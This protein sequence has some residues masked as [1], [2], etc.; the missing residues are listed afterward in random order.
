MYREAARI[1]PTL[2]DA[3][4]TLSTLG[5]TSEIVLVDDGSGDATT[6]A[7]GAF[8]TDS[9]SGWLLRVRLVRHAVNRGKG[10]AV[11]TGLGESRGSWRLM[12]DA[13]NATRVR[14]V[15]KLLNGIGPG[16]GLVAGSRCVADS[17]VEARGFRVF[18]GSVFKLGLFALGLRLCRDTQCG[19]KLYRGDV[20]D[21]VV[22]HGVE[23]RFAF[24]IEHLLL[25]RRMGVAVREV[26]VRWRHVDGGTINPVIDGLRMLARAATI[27]VRRYKGL[28]DLR[29][30]GR[31]EREIELKPVSAVGV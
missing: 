12:M 7:V 28:P 27:R 22:R 18:A 5:I 21:A 19:F 29:G 1:A 17:D 9:R 13:D 24:D 2:T 6:D 8:V 26:G 11:R 16:V 3:I 10:A 15:S 20:A 4:G 25:A 31:A 14:E 23:D 30:S